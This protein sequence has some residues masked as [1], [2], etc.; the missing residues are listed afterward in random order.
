MLIR[1]LVALTLVS[2]AVPAVAQ[3]PC[4]DIAETMDAA[5]EAR[6]MVWTSTLEP[7]EPVFIRV[8]VSPD[9][10]TYTV[11]LVAQNGSQSCVLDEGV[12]E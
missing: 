11:E 6:A 5:R 1:T 10:K 9:D 7:A 4:I 2:A 12:V 8:T 3:E